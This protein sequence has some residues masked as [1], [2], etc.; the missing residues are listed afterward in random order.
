[1]TGMF[2]MATVNIRPEVIYIPA[3]LPTASIP[4]STVQS[5][6]TSSAIVTSTTSIVTDCPYVL[7]HYISNL[8][9]SFSSKPQANKCND[10]C[11]TEH[12][13]CKIPCSSIV[14]CYECDTKMIE[15]I[16]SCPCRGQCPAG[17]DGCQNSV[18]PLVLI[19]S[20]YKAESVPVLTNEAGREDKDFNFEIDEEAQVWGSCSLTWENE[21]Y[22]FGGLNKKT[23][24]SKVTSCRLAPIGTLLFEHFFGDCVN[25]AGRKIAS[26]STMRE[27]TT[28]NVE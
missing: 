18:C 14:T 4:S 3:P 20:N 9:S 13:I 15:C 21:L 16:D 6:T 27:T 28:T 2:T 22:V 12:D 25:V 19:L 26:A 24:I 8:K 23:Q 7:E 17:C 5:T 1:M 10:I 11:K